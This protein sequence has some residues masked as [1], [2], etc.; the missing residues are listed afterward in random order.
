V[1]HVLA[2]AVIADPELRRAYC[3][4]STSCHQVAVSDQ[5]T[6]IIDLRHDDSSGPFETCLVCLR[7]AAFG[8]SRPLGSEPVVVGRDPVCDYP[9][10]D[11]AIS[12][13]HFRIEPSG[14]DFRLVDLESRNGTFLN[15]VRLQ[16]SAILKDGDLIGIG[17]HV[18]KFLRR[19]AVEHAYHERMTQLS[20]ADEL[21]GAMN[22]RAILDVLQRDMTAATRESA[23]I[24]VISLDIDRFKTI[25]DTRGHAVGD[26]VLIEVV[27]RL[28]GTLRQNDKLGRVG[29]EEFLVVLPDTTRDMAVTL[30]ER[31]RKMVANAPIRTD[32]EPLSVTVSLGVCERQQWIQDTGGHPELSRC[33]E[34]MLA[35]ADA[36]LYDAK[37]AGRNRVAY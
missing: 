25:N 28:Q 16:G 21:T 36:R 14:E 37:N 35:V 22:R 7:G 12:R 9:L 19:N 18:F 24:A 1:K 11:L 4:R 33:I 27:K 34:A 5:S 23:P 3:V 26:V 17:A 32:G 13:Q 10:D 6:T 20:M 30:A 15:R 31:L 8:E 29:G 2:H